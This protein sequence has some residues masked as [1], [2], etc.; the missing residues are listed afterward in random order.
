MKAW[1]RVSTGDISTVYKKLTLHH[2]QQRAQISRDT[3]FQKARVVETST[4]ILV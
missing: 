3:A 2:T 1:I 4:E